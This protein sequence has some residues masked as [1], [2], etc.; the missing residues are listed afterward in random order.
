MDIFGPQWE[1]HWDKIQRNW[2]GIVD[3]EDC[4]LIPG[5]ISW[6]M[7]LGCY[8]RSGGDRPTSWQE[9]NGSRE[10]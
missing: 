10:S 2:R 4:V 9:D 7:K 3:D 1:N 5:D 8:R 6:A